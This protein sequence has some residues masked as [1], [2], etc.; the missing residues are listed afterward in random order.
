[1]DTLFFHSSRFDYYLCHLQKNQEEDFFCSRNVK[2]ENVYN[3]CLLFYVLC[4]AKKKYVG[5]RF[6]LIKT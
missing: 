1:M 3:E 6:L 4:K 5:F 2:N